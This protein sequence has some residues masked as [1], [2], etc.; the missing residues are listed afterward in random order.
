MDTNKSYKLNKPKDLLRERCV[1]AD[2][3][4]WLTI[5]NTLP[6]ITSGRVGFESWS[7]SKKPRHF[8]FLTLTFKT[9]SQF[10]VR[11]KAFH[12]KEKYYVSL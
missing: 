10:T 11:I 3:Q 2:N 12:K 4:M 5:L 9:S 8:S 7:T 6:K 1:F